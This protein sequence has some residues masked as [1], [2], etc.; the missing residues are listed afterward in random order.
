VYAQALTFDDDKRRSDAFN[1]AHGLDDAE[2]TLLYHVW[3]EQAAPE[4]FV[5]YVYNL[6]WD[7]SPTPERVARD[8]AA[9]DRL[10]ARGLV[11]IL[12]AEAI[13]AEDQRVAASDVPE[14]G[15][16]CRKIP[17]WVE[18]TAAGYALRRA[19]TAALFGRT[20][21]ET[22]VTVTQDAERTRFDVYSTTTAAC[23]ELLDR[24]ATSPRLYNPH[25]GWIIIE[26]IEPSACGP[27][28]ANQFTLHERGFH[29]VLRLRPPAG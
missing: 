16:H 19:M 13:T 26:R 6:G 10:I 24:I 25:E 18:F 9:L 8:L 23:K 21:D 2:A 27:W 11:T 29:A 7:K 4:D 22:D 28:R 5:R 17:G 3:M 12:T 20:Q 14:C 1:A 15:R